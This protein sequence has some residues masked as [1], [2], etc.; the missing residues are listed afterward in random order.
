MSEQEIMKS[1]KRIEKRLE[2]IDNKCDAV[3]EHATFVEGVYET[4][5]APLDF[6]TGYVSSYMPAA[7]Q[8]GD[9]PPLPST[10]KS[11]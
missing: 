6:I 1:L 8:D 3:T 4:M 11:S 2:A 5:R 10:K 9:R 7:I